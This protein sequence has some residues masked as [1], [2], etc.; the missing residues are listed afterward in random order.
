M[1]A[2]SRKRRWPWIAAG[3]LLV[4]AAAG[5]VATKD[6][7]YWTFLDATGFA[8]SAEALE[9]NT[10][11]RQPKRPPVDLRLYQ[12]FGG[13]SDFGLAPDPASSR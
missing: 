11:A 6:Q 1:Q 5:A 8:C 3:G 10:R 12:N 13:S 7:L 2:K 9:G 4:A